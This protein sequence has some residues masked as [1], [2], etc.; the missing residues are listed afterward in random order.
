[1]NRRMERAARPVWRPTGAAAN[2]SQQRVYANGLP[3]SRVKTLE[4][5]ADVLCLLSFFPLSAAERT[6]FSALF[7]RRMER[8][9]AAAGNAQGGHLDGVESTISGQR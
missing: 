6:G 7:V 8:A 5:T 4:Q 1:M 3:A 2:S 9:Y